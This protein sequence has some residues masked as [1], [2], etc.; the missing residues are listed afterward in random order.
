MNYT[1]FLCN[2]KQ[3]VTEHFDSSFNVS[4]RTIEKNNGKCLDGLII[5]NPDYNIS[6]TIYLNP[7]Y[8]RYLDG[9][10]LDDIFEDIITTY[11]EYMPSDNFDINAITHFATCKNSI[12]FKLIN[13]KKNEDMLSHIP[14]FKY[15]DFAIIFQILLDKNSYGNA[16][17][18]I[19]EQLLNKWRLSVDDLLNVA[20]INT[21]LLLPH[22][23]LN[24][25]DLIPSDIFPC[26]F[27][28]ELVDMYVLTNTNKINGASVILY[29]GL[30]NQIS[31]KLHSD[32][33]LLPSSIHEFIILPHNN[34]MSFN[35]MTE[36]VNSVNETSVSDEEVLSNHVYFYDSK[37]KRLIIP[38]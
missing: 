28:D 7:Y 8:H 3:S 22:Q 13:Y 25:S 33:V 37:S 10:S 27:A 12:A 31:K 30:L 24:L 26:T 21:P 35:A 38:D 32:L 6:P 1:E 9:V 2:I 16:S 11:N 34:N 20:L 36:M 14:H 23:L 29:D 4:I 17:I 5:C 15:L 19:H 18:T